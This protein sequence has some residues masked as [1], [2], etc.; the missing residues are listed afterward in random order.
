MSGISDARLSFGHRSQIINPDRTTSHLTPL[1]NTHFKRHEVITYRK[2]FVFH[3]TRELDPP[4]DPKDKVEGKDAKNEAD[5]RKDED[6]EKENAS[7]VRKNMRALL[8]L[9]SHFQ[10]LLVVA[11]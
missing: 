1:Q 9:H 2:A 4:E 10:Q 6:G 7:E 3:T 8:S 5:K 11:G